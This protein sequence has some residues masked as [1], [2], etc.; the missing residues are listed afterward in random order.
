[1]T[2]FSVGHDTH[3]IPGSTSSQTDDRK[4]PKR[5]AGS[6]AQSP[7]RFQTLP[8]FENPY[9]LST[10]ARRVLGATQ[11]KDSYANPIDDEIQH[12]NGKTEKDRNLG[13]QCG[14]L[15][16]RG[17]PSSSFT[18]KPSESHFPRGT[19]YSQ[20]PTIL[21]SRG[22]SYHTKQSQEGSERDRLAN[23]D[24]P[25]PGG[26]TRSIGCH[27]FSLQPPTSGSPQW[28]KTLRRH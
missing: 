26:S 28:S 3:G 12:P 16:P 9:A 14:P 23:Y 21:S 4:D 2:E 13:S 10:S 19:G 18:S 1:M 8:V 25:A 22:S 5:L 11:A 24:Q 6:A 15:E 20:P 27:I 7:S 17:V